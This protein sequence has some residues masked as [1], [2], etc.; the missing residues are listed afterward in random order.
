VLSP[1]EPGA[2]E[3]AAAALRAGGLVAFPTD[4]LYGV[5]A[6]AHDA[7]AVDRLY[8]AKE[9]PMDKGMPILLADPHDLDRVAERISPLAR[10]LIVRFWPGPLTLIVPKKADLPPA[11][12]PNQGVAVRMPDHGL[13][14]ALIRAAGG[15]LAVSSANRTGSEPARTAAEALAALE[16]RVDLILDGGSVPIGVPST[17]L[18]CT[19][20]PARVLRDG[21][22]APQVLAAAGSEAE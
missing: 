2:L 10:R 4:T 12:S 5:G 19:V 9:R 20:A 6:L 11:I 21:A 14:R 16:G 1:D 8:L 3:Q 22:I 7:A 18:D 17:I 13:A 15:A